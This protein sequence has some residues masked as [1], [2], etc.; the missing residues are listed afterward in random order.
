MGFDIDGARKAGYSDDQI[1][2]Y[3]GE[4]KGLDVA[5]ARKAGYTTDRLLVELSDAF[6][7]RTPA[8]PSPA[9][10]NAGLSSVSGARRG[11]TRAEA[12]PY[13]A[14]DPAISADPLSQ[15]APATMRQPLIE[16][17]GAPVSDEVF[18]ATVAQLSAMPRAQRQ[19]QAKRTDL[20]GWMQETVLKAVEQIDGADAAAQRVDMAGPSVESRTARAMRQGA[21]LPTATAKATTDAMRGAGASPLQQAT[22]GPGLL[23]GEE[24]T[25]NKAEGEKLQRSSLAARGLY[26]AREGLIQGTAG[27][28][29]MGLRA[30]GDEETAK[31]YEKVG[32]GASVRAEAANELAL[33][34]EKARDAGILPS[35]PL[36]GVADFTERM[37][38]GAANS[39]GQMLPGIAAGIATGNAGVGLAMMALPVFGQ[40][41]IDKRDAGG[42]PGMSAAYGGAMAALEIV[43]ERYGL[44]PQALNAFKKEAAKKSLEEVPAFI[45][46]GIAAMEKRGLFSKPV[47]AFVRGQ[48][49]EQIGEQITGAGQYLLDG[50]AFG[51]DKP[52]SL[53]GFIENARDTAVQTLLATGVMQ[54]AG[55][56][57]KGALRG[58][59]VAEDPNA[60]GR[61]ASA[62]MAQPIPQRVE[63]TPSAAPAPAAQN[64]A[65]PEAQPGAQAVDNITGILQQAGALPED[66]TGLDEAPQAAAPAAGRVDIRGLMSKYTGA[67]GVLNGNAAAQAIVDHA[68]QALNAGQS[69]TLMADGKPR[70]ITNIDR[71]MMA[72]ESGQRWGTLTLMTDPDGKRGNSLVIGA[73]PVEGEKINRNWSAFAPES[74][75]LGIPRADMP[76]IGAEHRGAFVNFLASRGI[77]RTTEELPADSLKPTQAEFSP[78]RVA[79]ARERKGG[80]RSIIVSS[81]GYVIDGHHQWMAAREAG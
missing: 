79:Q 72:D 81:D 71:G 13:V 68:R 7:D 12:R 52:I 39:V 67:D 50:T 76:Q 9:P 6:V 11:G 34:Q 30:A 32:Q 23:T 27:L 17:R 55:A 59:R 57:A 35:G 48:A 16:Q 60:A 45:E 66:F 51:L 10:A 33:M 25:A 4:Q 61:P 2:D 31:L 8:A 38:T 46:R 1:A 18:K 26:G 19:A 80:D 5:A 43:G 74:G 58:T 3:L 21:D 54:A 41:Y 63:P 42:T 24:V 70:N 64:P 28:I 49:G 78:R 14:P 20:P 62:P 36:S 22:A 47:G 15:P 40:S 65:Q 37:G 29:A 69:V 53:M 77:E 73:S 75:T 44:L 56:G